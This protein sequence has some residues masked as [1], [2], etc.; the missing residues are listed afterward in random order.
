M[1]AV[2]PFAASGI[3]RTRILDVSNKACVADTAPRPDH[4]IPSVEYC[5]VPFPAWLVIAMPLTA[6]LSTSAHDPDVRIELKVVPDEVVFS[7]VPVN[8]T[9]A[10]FVMVGA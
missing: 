5:H 10:P 7:S 4:V 9:V 3:Y 6:P 2:S 1:T 8:V